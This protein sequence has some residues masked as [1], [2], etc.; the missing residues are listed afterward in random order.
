MTATDGTSSD[1][2]FFLHFVASTVSWLSRKLLS[3]I[4]WC[5]LLVACVLPWRWGHISKEARHY[6]RDG[7]SF[8]GFGILHLFYTS[9]DLLTIPVAFGA[10]LTP[11]LPVLINTRAFCVPNN[12]GGYDGDRRL[13]FW[14]ALFFGVYELLALPLG[15]FTILIP[16]R[17]YVLCE[18]LTRICRY[19]ED[20]GWGTAF[21]EG[22]A[23]E[24]ANF[25][26]ECFQGALLDLLF[27]GVGAAA[28][29][30]LPTG[31]SLWWSA[32]TQLFST[33]RRK[34]TVLNIR[35]S[36]NVESPTDAEE[37]AQQNSRTGAAMLQRNFWRWRGQMLA[38][39]CL[40]ALD[41]L[42]APL[43]LLLL[44]S[45]V[46]TLPF[47]TD[48]REL[49]RERQ[50]A[51]AADPTSSRRW[52][53]WS[54]WGYRQCV[55]QHTSVICLDLIFLPFPILLG[56]TWYRSRPMRMAIGRD[57]RITSPAR[58]EILRGTALLLL[59]MLMLPGLLL[60]ILTWRRR[61][62]V[63]EAFAGWDASYALLVQYHLA[64]R[65]FRRFC[66]AGTDLEERLRR[67][68]IARNAGGDGEATQHDVG[69]EVQ[70][71]L[72]QA[73]HGQAGARR[74][75]RTLNRELQKKYVSDLAFQ[76]AADVVSFRKQ[77]SAI[78]AIDSQSQES[79]SPRDGMM[80]EGA[81]DAPCLESCAGGEPS[82]E[83]APAGD[84]EGTEAREGSPVTATSSEV[85]GVPGMETLAANDAAQV[86]EAYGRAEL[87][88]QLEISKAAIR[89]RGW[90]SL[91][92]PLDPTLGARRAFELPSLWHRRV[93]AHLMLLLVD[94]AVLPFVLLVQIT[95]YRVP[96]MRSWGDKDGDFHCAV[97]FNA[98]VVVHDMCLVV[99]AILPL[100]CP[101]YRL[102]VVW[103]FLTASQPRQDPQDG[104]SDA[105]SQPP[106]IN[107][108]LEPG[109]HGGIREPLLE[110]R[111]ACEETWEE[112]SGWRGAIW[113]QAGLLLVDVVIGLPA[114]AAVVATLVRL[115]SLLLAL[116]SKL[117]SPARTEACLRVRQLSLRVPTRGRD[118]R[119]R[120]D[121]EGLVAPGAAEAARTLDQAR[122]LRCWVIG[123]DMFW[124]GAGQAL[125]GAL[126]GSARA[127]LP[128]HIAHNGKDA[129]VQVTL[130]DEGLSVRMWLEL[131]ANV[132][133][134]NLVQLLRKFPS[135]HAA[136]QG[137]IIRLQV[138]AL[139]PD[140]NE[141]PQ[142]MF[143]IALPTG[144]LADALHAG[145]HAHLPAEVTNPSPPSLDGSVR[146]DLAGGADSQREGISDGGGGGGSIRDSFTLVAVMQA[147]ELA[148]DVAHLGCF[149][150]LC[151][152]PWRLL[153]TLQVM[154]EPEA[155]WSSRVA[156]GVVRNLK[157][158]DLQR[159]NAR[160]RL[161]SLCTRRS[162]EVLPG[163]WWG[164][165]THS[166]PFVYSGGRQ[167]QNL[168]ME[169]DSLQALTRDADLMEPL[170]ATLRWEARLA[171]MVQALPL[172]A[173]VSGRLQRYV[174][175]ERCR[176]HYVVL[177]YVLHLALL[178][179]ALSANTHATAV[180]EILQA[181][182]RLQAAG[183]RA[184]QS[185]E[186][187]A[188]GLEGECFAQLGGGWGP[189]NKEIEF[190][191][192][193]IRNQML[194]GF[195]DYGALVLLL[196]LVSTVYRLPAMFRDMARSGS[197]LFIHTSTKLVMGIH[198]RRVA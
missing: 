196:V 89:H 86:A 48:L 21:D 150:L 119:P 163:A 101:G 54:L 128:V 67:F 71:M 72:T 143:T 70:D 16:T 179:G 65:R 51:A 45:V 180:C 156:T 80:G 95:R 87:A 172:A 110:P 81:L 36:W 133:R 27:L 165:M 82:H 125:G 90:E 33:G 68:L 69:D 170:R 114:A 40:A 20:A 66:R 192:R 115:P 159:G 195:S 149:A 57:G 148:L 103:P 3:L 166:G 121:L 85:R 145:E 41:M 50:S 98:A 7:A 106:I 146:D 175:L 76:D 190:S 117:Y 39:V 22:K 154:F 137:P 188:E 92:G 13:R 182:R 94:A 176:F 34:T 157:F 135:S 185:L 49:L 52:I 123:D 131:P 118:G 55:L 152:A 122:C 140:P 173:E 155:R 11:A 83:C 105:A 99:L 9:V 56:L 109:L 168:V 4:G 96:V 120:L 134:S 191:R 8:L 74:V 17:T 184:R 189:W 10:V 58:R 93:I 141:P 151:L 32:W 61:S 46:R 139:L 23:L 111:D 177:T 138:E 59:D 30:L 112:L 53:G 186:A 35:I 194:L 42:L 102:P 144:Q 107:P 130:E 26:V 84:G 18:G 153:A 197:Y 171:R 6:D 116:R 129:S 63:L 183:R 104:P 162:K 160:H 75:E 78:K 97:L 147:V 44:V 174:A 100:A 127:M 37:A 25:T 15:I 77:V 167:R 31:P 178:T 91:N 88:Y 142:R 164:S 124:Q 187:C 14:A 161:E 132:R 79:G 5:C 62:V 158:V 113:K 108:L 193:A 12:Q 38:S 60:L 47:I 29:P 126:A 73:G 198:L 28:L 1:L 2:T 43:A 136:P 181:D 24:M 169:A 64:E 19:Y